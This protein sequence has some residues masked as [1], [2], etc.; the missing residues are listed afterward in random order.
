VK[1]DE[2]NTAKEYEEVPFLITGRVVG[3]SA[4]RFCARQGEKE[5]SPWRHKYPWYVFGDV[6][7]V[8]NRH[9]IAV[10]LMPAGLA[11]WVS[12]QKGANGWRQ[13]STSSNV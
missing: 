10:L 4:P 1:N 3:R 7:T 2:V 9:G 11:I 8:A 6:P 13:N 12:D 5:R